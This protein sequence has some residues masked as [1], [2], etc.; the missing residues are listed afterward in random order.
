M[1]KGELKMIHNSR[2]SVWL[3]FMN[4]RRQEKK[5][6]GLDKTHRKTWKVTETGTTGFY[7]STG[8]LVTETRPTIWVSGL[9][10][11]MFKTWVDTSGIT[12]SSDE[13]VHHK[14]NKENTEFENWEVQEKSN[15]LLF[16][17][18]VPAIW[19]VQ[20]DCILDQY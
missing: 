4:V 8:L 17:H 19:W 2:L 11:S 14:E 16:H 10:V 7:G 1:C 13:M 15:K 9:C 18:D 5:G 6:Q 20:A 12:I 3:H